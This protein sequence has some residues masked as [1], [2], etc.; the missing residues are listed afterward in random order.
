MERY[1]PNIP[2]GDIA[3][4]GTNN[5][6]IANG[7]DAAGNPL[8]GTPKAR[9]SV[10]YLV[11]K[12]R[13]IN[14]DITLTK[15]NSP[16]LV[17]NNIQNFQSGAVLNIEP[18]VVIKFYNDAGW[19]FIEGS[20]IIAQGSESEPIVFTSFYDDEYGGDMNNDATSTSPNPGDWYGIKIK[21]DSGSLLKHTIFRYGG[22]YYYG[23]SGLGKAD[24]TVEDCS[25][26]VSDSVFERSEIYGLKLSNSDSSIL[27]NNFRNNNA[28]GDPAGYDGAVFALGGAPAIKNNIFKGNAR[29]IVLAGS[30]AV[31]DSNT[32]DSNRREAIYSFNSPE[33]VFINNSGENNTVNGILLSGDITIKNST[34]TLEINKLPY[35]MNDFNVGVVASST[36]VVPAGI[37]LK[38]SAAGLNVFGNLIVEGE[39]AGDITFTSFYDDSVGGD[40]NND[41]TSTAPGA[42][43]WK[44][45][46]MKPGSYSDIRGATFKYADTALTYENSPINLTNVEFFSN[47]ATTTLK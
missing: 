5:G 22:K 8:N 18:G 11:N 3:N 31:V 27:N 30:R 40:T 28:V 12:G 25:L 2:G 41:A 37:I 23:G 15:E 4:W 29:G 20:K 17:D 7:K 46:W 24:L 21:S 19:R 45:I 32:F 33:N 9:N 10:N 42:G 6:V 36:L 38:A 39:N 16:Y 14:S 1:D 35:V 47:N 43:Q 34:T 44:G 13:E 26:S